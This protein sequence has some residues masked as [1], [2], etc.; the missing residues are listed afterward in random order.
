MIYRNKAST[1]TIGPKPAAM[2]VQRAPMH[3]ERRPFIMY[4]RQM[5]SLNKILFTDLH[6]F[7]VAGQCTIHPNSPTQGHI[8]IHTSA[9]TTSLPY[10]TIHPPTSSRSMNT[11]TC[12]SPRK[13][14]PKTCREQ[15]GNQSLIYVSYLAHNSSK[16]GKYSLRKA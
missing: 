10:S 16:I 13:Q 4:L 8:T 12:L 1:K 6:Q 9:Q 2:A 14:Q 3:T 11:M 5:R 7:T 15:H